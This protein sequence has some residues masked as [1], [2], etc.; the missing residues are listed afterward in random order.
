MAYLPSTR[1]DRSKAIMAAAV[2]H[3]GMA[4][5]LLLDG[6]AGAPTLTSP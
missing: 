1:A 6:G 4:A 2:V 5:L 3:V